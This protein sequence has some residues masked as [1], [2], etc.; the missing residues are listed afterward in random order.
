MRIVSRLVEGV[1]EDEENHFTDEFLS[2]NGVNLLGKASG[3]LTEGRFDGFAKVPDK[4]GLGV[5]LNEKVVKEHLKKGELYFAPTTEWDKI[6]SW[7][8]E[9]S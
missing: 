5:E 1:N 8:R 9:W 3:K 7:D 2:R 6:D 4:P